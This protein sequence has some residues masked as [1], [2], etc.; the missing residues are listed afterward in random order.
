[1]LLNFILMIKDF[2]CSMKIILLEFKRKMVR[3]ARRNAA[4]WSGEG[5]S[6]V[7]ELMWTSDMWLASGH[8]ARRREALEKIKESSKYWAGGA[9]NVRENMII[10]EKKR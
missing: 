10:K 1:M 8:G 5:K 9:Q 3:Q 2:F 4:A 6:W 7:F